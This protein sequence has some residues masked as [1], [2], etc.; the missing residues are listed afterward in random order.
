M[1]I[2]RREDQNFPLDGIK[3]FVA[4]DGLD[5]FIKALE[6]DF[7]ANVE[8]Q[9]RYHTDNEKTDLILNLHCNYGLTESLHHFNNGNWGG[10]ICGPDKANTICSFDAAFQKLSDANNNIVDIAEA[11]IHFKDTSIIVTRIYDYSIP[12]QLG[13]IIVK[14]SEHFVYI[15]K[16]LTEMPYEIFVPV[17]EQHPQNVCTSKKRQ[18]CYFD[19]W[20][21]YFENDAHHDVMVYALETKKLQKEDFFL[22]D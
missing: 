6:R 14:T 10:F 2:Q 17:F 9:C 5:D 19:F 22:L 13:E 15:T 21:L 20:G 11:S 4:A 1:P 3:T 18:K 16:G 7:F 8:M 12:E